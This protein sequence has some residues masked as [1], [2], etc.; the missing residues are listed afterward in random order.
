MGQGGS[1]VVCTLLI[2]GC[3]DRLMW[4]AARVGERVPFV[5]EEADCYL[6]R[7]PAGFVNMVHKRDALVEMCKGTKEQK[8]KGV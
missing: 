3:A 8:S 5:R 7:E 1:I 4:Y 2:T 6:S